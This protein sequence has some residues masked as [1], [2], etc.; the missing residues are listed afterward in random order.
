M[1]NTCCVPQCN[2]NYN[3]GENIRMFLFPKNV[4]KGQLWK[5]SIPR[6]NLV[7]RKCTSVCIK[8]FEEKFLVRQLRA[9]RLDG[10]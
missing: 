3:V 5:K 8:H 4:E 2:S 7:V 1:P 10:R 6:D 9:T